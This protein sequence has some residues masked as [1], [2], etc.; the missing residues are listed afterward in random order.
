MDYSFQTLEEQ[1]ALLVNTSGAHRTTADTTFVEDIFAAYSKYGHKKI[2]I[3]YRKAQV[4]IDVVVALGRPA[5]FDSLVGSSR[6]EKV[7]LV[8]GELNEQ[9]RYFESVCQNRGWNLIVADDY[10]SALK[11]LNA[12]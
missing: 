10:T 2:I 8:F 12:S 5:F 7:V 3:D 4:D 1:Q 11:W 6:P 9:Y